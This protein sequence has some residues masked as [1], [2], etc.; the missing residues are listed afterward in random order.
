M[1]DGRKM[2]MDCEKVRNSDDCVLLDRLPSYL[3]PF[4]FYLLPFTSYLYPP[5]I[6]SPD[7]R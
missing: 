3:L 2:G 5:K 7:K 4:T 6:A 1:G